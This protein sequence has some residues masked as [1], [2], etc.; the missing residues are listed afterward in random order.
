MTDSG[1]D[2][3]DE[4]LARTWLANA[5]LLDLKG[6]ALVADDG[7]RDF[8]TVSCLVGGHE[9]SPEIAADARVL[10]RPPWTL[11]SMP[12]P[13]RSRAVWADGRSA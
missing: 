9:R 2:N 3:T 8:T 10:A 6:T 13:R 12:R 5:C 4:H 7:G 1:C 11:T